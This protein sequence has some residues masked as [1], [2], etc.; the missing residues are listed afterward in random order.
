MSQYGMGVSASVRSSERSANF[1]SPLNNF[2][3]SHSQHASNSP[4]QMGR[5]RKTLPAVRPRWCWLR[6]SIRRTLAAG[7]AKECRAA[8]ELPL[9][10]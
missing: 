3:W 9:P 8:T 5:I 10:P 1:R 6:A 4:C 7:A 2:T